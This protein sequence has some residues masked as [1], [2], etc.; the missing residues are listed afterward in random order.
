MRL[1]RIFCRPMSLS[2]PSSPSAPLQKILFSQHFYNGLSVG[3]GVMGA[4]FLAYLASGGDLAITAGMASGAVCVSIAD[5]PSPA[6]HKRYELLAA[7]VFSVL[8]TLA[9]GFARHSL[10]TLGIAVLVL[11]FFT[12]LANAYGK[13]AMPVSFAAILAMIMTL[14]GPEHSFAEVP[15]AVALFAGG[16]MLYFVYALAVARRLE[17][18]TRQQAFAESCFELAQYLRVKAS[19]YGQDAT[20]D[21]CYGMLMRQQAAVVDKQQNARDFVLG[22]IG[23]PREAQLAQM[24]LA[25]FDLFESVLSSH[26]D[27]QLLQEWYG[28]S[29]PM[30]LLRDLVGK[31]ALDLDRVAYTALRDSEAP[32]PVNYKAEIFALR[33]E[34]ERLERETAA[35]GMAAAI[36]AL[37]A[38]KEA[39]ERI[40]QCVV[41][42]QSLHEIAQKPLCPEAVAAG[43]DLQPF[44]TPASYSPRVL[45]EH[46]RLDSPFFRYALRMTLAMGCGFLV[47]YL[48]PYSTHS[49]WILLTIAVVMRSNFS[50][51]LQRRTD[52]ILGNLT[53]CVLTALLLQFT[54]HPAALLLALFASLVVAQTFVVVRYRYTAIAS[55]VMALL[56]IHFL[57][58][59]IPFAIGERLIDTLVGALFAYG[60]SFILPS[61]EYRD[62]PR[63]LRDLLAA[64][65][66]YVEAVLCAS[67]DFDY[68]LARKAMFDNIAAVT[69]AFGRMLQEPAT[70]RRAVAVTQSFITANYLFAAHVAALHVLV[71]RLPE[72]EKREILGRSGDHR[73]AIQGCLADAQDLVTRAVV[74]ETG[75]AFVLGGETTVPE[76]AP[77]VTADPRLLIAQRIRVIDADAE[78]IRRL[79]AKMA[80]AEA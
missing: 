26:T 59:G 52:R 3:G 17:F 6:R 48:L 15:R 20:L 30:M 72:A 41:L 18:R 28:G 71:K 65:R 11:S 79:A 1:F 37:K 55:C 8:A 58:P 50:M 75:A 51:T 34:I 57:N 7:L 5:I 12:A 46:C 21:E 62:L 31:A 40:S 38:F 54:R 33:Y 61:W 39:F 64:N 4:V 80:M 32:H 9:V 66:R 56:Q 43:I 29:D 42:V 73:E 60:F 27:Y 68:R 2:A 70:R 78:E 24:L 47:A 36:T 13:K 22:R 19:F 53:G 67:S 16:G 44:L 69:G 14:G 45:L 49:Y 35:E 63:R 76:T 25:Q 77:A 23:T 74:Q 10:W